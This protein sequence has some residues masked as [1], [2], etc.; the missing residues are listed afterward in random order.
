MSR[1]TVLLVLIVAPM[2]AWQTNA[3][4]NT[5]EL[6]QD[7]ISNSIKPPIPIGPTSIPQT[8]SFYL[9][10]NGAGNGAKYFDPAKKPLTV[11]LS[12]DDQAFLNVP[13]HVT[14]ITFGAASG[15]SQQ[16]A[17]GTRVA[18]T[19][20]ALT[21]TASNL[22]TAHPDGPIGNGINLNSNL[23][24]QIFLSAKPLI[25]TMAATSDASR[26][27]YGKLRLTFSRPVNDPVISLIGLGATT[28][29]SGKRLGFSTE[30]ELVTE[31]IN[32]VKLSGTPELVLDQTGRKILHS[33]T[34]VSGVCGK[35]AACGSIL[36]KAS[37]LTTATFE[38]YLRPDGRAGSWGT[39]KVANAGDMWHITISL[40]E[41]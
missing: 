36:L 11:T 28:F 33:N 24:V 23:G 14:G 13:Q 15:K 31:S 22:F 2:I 39:D 30:L 10:R 40:P 32:L 19:S 7:G 12:L 21:D 4:K 27:Y 20:Y 16:N 37:Q 6:V 5:L 41:N 3:Q 18:N 8:L 26:Y 35:G 38:V 25:T 1:S 9:N 29:F 34:P 17:I